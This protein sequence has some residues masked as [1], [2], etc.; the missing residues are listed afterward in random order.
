MH[1]TFRISFLT[2]CR[3]DAAAQYNLQVKLNP[4]EFTMT[5]GFSHIERMHLNYLLSYGTIPSSPPKSTRRRQAGINILIGHAPE[6]RRPRSKTYQCPYARRDESACCKYTWPMNL[7]E[8]P[9]YFKTRGR[10]D[11]W[12]DPSLS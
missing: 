7:P 12:T 5:T 6:N 9:Q 3:H 8:G 2:R 10:E 4:T 11:T 1:G